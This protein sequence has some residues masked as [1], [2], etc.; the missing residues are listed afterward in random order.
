[1]RLCVFHLIRRTPRLALTRSAPFIPL[2]QRADMYLEGGDQHRGWFQSSLLTH[3]GATGEARAPY[4]TLVTHGFV[5]DES[6]AK[7]SKSIGNV[8]TPSDLIDGPPTVVSPDGVAGGG[9]SDGGAVAAGGG[10]SQAAAPKPARKTK[11]ERKQAREKR[12]TD[13]VYGADVLRL[14]VAMVRKIR[15][16]STAKPVGK[17]SVRAMGSSAVCSFAMRCR[18]CRGCGTWLTC[19]H[20]SP[21]P[22]WLRKP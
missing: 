11:K 17:R 5:V 16:E 1:M 14:W 13:G 15:F 12:E 7:M 10:D 3:V 20:Q 8:L 21:L 19:R 6:G 22:S 9:G 2:R 4:A 18:P